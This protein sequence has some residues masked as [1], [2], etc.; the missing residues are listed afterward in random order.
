MID[1]AARGD[2]QARIAFARQYADVVRRTL[3]FRWAG[4]ALA[5]QVDDAV[6]DVFLDC[7]KEEGALGRAERGRGAGF[8]GFLHGVVANVARRYERATGRARDRSRDL[9]PD[10]PDG[11]PTL[12]SAFDRA[13]LHRLLEL[14]VARMRAEAKDDE[15]GR[16]VDLLAMRFGD[17]LPIREIAAA[18]GR[19]A[20]DVHVA[21]ARA[22]REFRRALHA[23]MREHATDDEGP[24][25][26][27]L[28]DTLRRLL[29]A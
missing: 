23:V 11:A 25:P 15:A 9:R 12:E 14:A 7:F 17:G 29:E 24:T 5:Q 28:D 16:R 26:D 4:S 2:T 1:R 3:S 8:G 20:E 13:W 27:A 22:R 10:L 19:D 21:Y 6:Q 18:W